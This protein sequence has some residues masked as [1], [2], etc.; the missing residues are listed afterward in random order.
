MTKRDSV[1]AGFTFPPMS[2][3]FPRRHHSHA[4][5]PS[6]W[7]Y[8]NAPG[9]SYTSHPEYPSWSTSHNPAD[10][11]QPHSSEITALPAPIP[12]SSES[13]N[14]TPVI[15]SQEMNLP[16]VHPL[17]NQLTET[18][19]QVHA[20]YFIEVSRPG[21]DPNLPVDR[22]LTVIE[23]DQQGIHRH[24]QPE[25]FFNGIVG[26]IRAC[27]NGWIDSWTQS[28]QLANYWRRHF[29]IPE[30]HPN[31]SSNWWN[32]D[33]LDSQTSR[34]EPNMEDTGSVTAQ[35]DTNPPPVQIHQL[36]TLLWNI[37]NND[38]EANQAILE[39]LEDTDEDLQRHPVQI[40]AAGDLA[41]LA[42]HLA[43]TTRTLANQAFEMEAMSDLSE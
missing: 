6:D 11:D 31:R 41:H 13:G 25:Y 30:I 22:Y 37:L 1:A 15:P 23:V 20:H 9:T 8:S 26:H 17:H 28:N 14:Q 27:R 36:A 2:M 3:N 16:D 29:N 42:S 40:F 38:W 39:R 21:N 10:V 19:R 18:R 24:R 33:D 7:H 43:E 4:G 32:Y 35:V 5:Q 34:H 12:T